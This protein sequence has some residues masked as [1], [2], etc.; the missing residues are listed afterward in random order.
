VWGASPGVYVE[1]ADGSH[2]HVVYVASD[3]RSPVWS[4]DGSQIAFYHR[5]DGWQIINGYPARADFFQVI[6]VRPTDGSIWIPYNQPNHS[7]SPS[8][9]PDGQTLVFSGDSGLYLASVTKQ[10]QTIPNTSFQFTTPAWSPDG[11]RIAFSLW[12][13]DHW[14]IGVIGPDGTGLQVLTANPLPAG[15]PVNNAAATWSP[16]G[17]RLAFISDRSGSWNLYIMNRDG[18]SVAPTGVTRVTYTG[19]YDRVVAWKK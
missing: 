17:D 10:A 16:G 9:S 8:W 12:S 3:T 7:Y 2:R 1:N 11:T 15:Q 19:S 14:D 13:H 5:Y 18:S 6:V 4:P